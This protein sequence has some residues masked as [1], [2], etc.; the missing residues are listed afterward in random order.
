MDS[1]TNNNQEKE[2]VARTVQID[3]WSVKIDRRFASDL[4]NLKDTHGCWLQAIDETIEL[5]TAI[6]VHEGHIE[7]LDYRHLF[8]LIGNQLAIRADIKRMVRPEI[9]KIE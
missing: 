2:Q 8:N 5:L 6:G 9:T 4:R 7:N 1:N 3:E